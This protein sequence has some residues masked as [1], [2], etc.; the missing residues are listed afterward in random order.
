MQPRILVAYDFGPAGAKALAWAADLKTTTGG[1]PV[2]VVHVVDPAPPVAPPDVFPML[3]EQEFAALGA[4]LKREVGEID[5]TATTEVV[6]ERPAGKAL[7]A[8]ARRIK[9]DLIVMG[10][11]GRGGIARMVIGS[12]AEHVVR[13]APCPVVTVRIA[14]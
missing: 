9:A 8:I 1:P 6:L 13:H 2:H 4:S 10:T 12:V 7:L 11:H 3:S 14:T 5:P